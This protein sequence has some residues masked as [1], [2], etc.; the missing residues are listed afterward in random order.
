[1]LHGAI[2][3]SAL[4]SDLLKFL[5]DLRKTVDTFCNG[6]DLHLKMARHT[7]WSLILKLRVPE[8]TTESGSSIIH[9]S[10]RDSDVAVIRVKTEI[11]W[12][13]LSNWGRLWNLVVRNELF[14]R[15]MVKSPHTTTCLL[16]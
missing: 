15:L 12:R 16:A 3:R 4:K 2:S 7:R 10:N 6:T 1:M 11:T 5:I 14:R 8:F 13:R 9:R